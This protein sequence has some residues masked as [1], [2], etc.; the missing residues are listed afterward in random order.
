MKKSYKIQWGKLILC[1]VLI[2]GVLIT[3][4]P[5]V[6]TILSSIKPEGEIVRFP[7]T[8]LPENPTIKNYSIV[9]NQIDFVIYFRNSVFL[10]TFISLIVIYTSAIS[11]YVIAKMRFKGRNALFLLILVTMMFPWPITIIPLYQMMLKFGWDNSYIAMIIPSAFSA[12]GIFLMRQFC[13]T[14]PDDII[15]AARIDGANEF[16]IFHM[17]ILPM[18]W[19]PIAALGIFNFLWTWEDFLW[20]FLILN[21]NNLYTLTMGL[22]RFVGAHYA[23]TGPIIA[24]S[25]I[26]LLPIIIVYFI[27]QRKFIEGFTLSGLKE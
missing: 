13:I 14:I 21:S 16:R 22:N 12:F 15:D 4:F 19:P 9:W 1:I 18:L 2:I 20:P 11:G 10:A 27:F 17:I 26:A 7:P 24:G 6:W 8:F 3:L 5:V 25:T 23:R